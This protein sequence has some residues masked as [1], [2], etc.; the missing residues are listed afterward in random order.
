MNIDFSL[1]GL[2][3]SSL[4]RAR[5][6]QLQS[7]TNMA[8][9]HRRDLSRTDSGAYSLSQRVESEKRF[10]A[11]L[12]ST[13]P[14]AMSIAHTQSDS[15]GQMQKILTKMSEIASLAG[16]VSSNANAKETYQAQFDGL[17]EDFNNFAELEI[18]DTKIFGTS[19]S[20][21]GKE[22]LDSL[23]SH[24]LAATEKLVLEKYGWEADPDDSW[25]LV[26]EEN[27][28][29]GG[30][31]A[32]VQSSWSSSD[33]VS[34]VTKLSI[35]LPD[36]QA[37]HTVGNSTADTLI[38]HEMV[39]L[40][41]AQNTYMGDQAGGEPGRDMAWFA[42]GLAELIRGADS[43]V[44]RVLNSGT[45]VPDIVKLPGAGWNGGE[46]DY[47]A[48]YLAVKFLDDKI[49]SSHSADG[50]KNLTT[51]M[52]TQKGA[53]AGAAL[54]GLN[55]YL[56]TELGGY[57]LGAGETY[58]DK[59]LEDF[60]GSNGQNFVNSINLANSDTGSI[61]GSDYGGS[62]LEDAEIVNDDSSYISG[63]TSKLSYEEDD[64]NDPVTL[65]VSDGISIQ[66]NTIDTFN[67][68]DASIYDLTTENGAK[69]TIDRVD[70]LLELL[71]NNISKVGSNMTAI[72]NHT[73]LLSVR[74]LGMD[75]NLTNLSGVSIADEM[76]TLSYSKILINSN[77]SMRVQAMD[78]QRSA[79]LS[80]LAA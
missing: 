12:S 47:A 75:K 29:K 18:N 32:F 39:H 64:S 74:Q 15:L 10:E 78:I 20:E 2:A 73:N 63:F 37:P 66:L 51:W 33:Y 1:G 50:I 68:G 53:G 4:S 26:I 17:I 54:S 24:W 11:G 41:Q 31:A 44:S 42:E 67:F 80:L 56:K 19:Q 28:A 48:A 23:K 70:E 38:A 77:L 62:P 61:A 3:N 45:S 76:E 8:A 14:N 9:G 59:F 21:E 57:T 5:K 6:S 55:E 34:Q 25:D 13:L 35:D 65:T 60:E 7:M 40:L 79:T 52:K 43:S 69:L 71:A 22:L 16:S 49:R 58:T 46:A 36:L 72:E 30:S 27:G